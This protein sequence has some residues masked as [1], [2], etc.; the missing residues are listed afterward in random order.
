MRRPDA[1]PPSL[2][3]ICLDSLSNVKSF[4]FLTISDNYS[5]HPN[6]LLMVNKSKKIEVNER[7]KPNIINGL[8]LPFSS[9]LGVFFEEDKFLSFFL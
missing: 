7:I 2:N 5:N 8:D 9:C 3:A 4:L 1:I 6:L